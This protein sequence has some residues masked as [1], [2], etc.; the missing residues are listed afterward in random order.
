MITYLKRIFKFAWT[1]FSRNWASNLVAIFIMVLVISSISSLF[2]FQGL[3]QFLISKIQGR[4]DIS[5]YFREEVTESEVLNVKEE[6]SGNSSGIEEIKYTSKTEALENFI[7]KHKD[8]PVFMTALQEVGSNPFLASLEIKTES[9]DQYEKVS[10]FLTQE[11]FS[12]LVE[13]I[14]YFQ[15]KP[16]IKKISST[17]SDVKK[18][19]IGLSVILAMIAVLV[20]FNA[21]KLTVYSSKEE[22]NTMKMVGASDGFVRGPFIIQGALY[23]LLACL[24]SLL[25]LSSVFYLSASRMESLL[26]GFNLFD[27]FVNNIWILIGL[28][29][30]FGVGLGVASSLVVTHKHLKV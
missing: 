28:Q 9:P 15:R 4:I 25:I 1:D 20:I 14:D 18:I 13:K 12:G 30:V 11:R 21:I 6:L 22:I 2:I 23:G 16:L 19:G 10:D 3:G 7:E 27:Y 5:V 24:I 17:I 8:N 26:L 29:L